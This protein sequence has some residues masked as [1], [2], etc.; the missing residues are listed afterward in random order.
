VFDRTLAFLDRNRIDALN[1]LI[2]T[3]CPGTKLFAQ[4]DSQGRVIDKDWSHYDFHHVVFKPTCM[5]LHELKE[6]ADRVLR[7]FYSTSRVA[8]RIARATHLGLRSIVKGILPVNL[9][10]W[11][12]LLRDIG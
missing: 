4:M 8:K 1:A 12:N 9:T 10:Y 7:D 5:A 11:H 2:M 3:P 6:G